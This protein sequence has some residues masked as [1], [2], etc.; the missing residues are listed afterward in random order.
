MVPTFTYRPPATSSTPH[1]TR[2][3][4][5]LMYCSSLVPS[6]LNFVLSASVATRCTYETDLPPRVSLPWKVEPDGI[7]VVR[8]VVA[9]VLVEPQVVIEPRLGAALNV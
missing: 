6:A 2:V 1:A 8:I 3:R 7:A 4:L 5:P 9:Q